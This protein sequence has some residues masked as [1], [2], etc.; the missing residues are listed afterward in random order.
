MKKSIVLIAL[1]LA[2]FGMQAQPQKAD[3]CYIKAGDKVYFGKDIV[4]GLIHTRVVLPDGLFAEFDN[5]EITA[6]KHHDKLYMLMPVICDKSDTLCLAMMEYIT[7]KS[8]YMVFRY[9]CST[10][11]DRLT[12]AKRNYF[13]VYKEG[14]FNCRISEDQTDALLSFGIKVI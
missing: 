6:Y 5:R 13:F 12:E 4:T 2:C 14:K 10:E 11:E 3:F 7:S 8:G 1:L 9:C